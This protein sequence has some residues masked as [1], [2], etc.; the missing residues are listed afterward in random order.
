MKKERKRKMFSGRKATIS[1][2]QTRENGGME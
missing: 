1:D 2:V